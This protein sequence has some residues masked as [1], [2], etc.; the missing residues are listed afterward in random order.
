[1]R[2]ERIAEKWL[3][4]HGYRILQR[5]LRIG[6]DEADLVARDPDGRT[7]VI[8]EVKTR[9]DRDSLPEARVDHRKV[10]RLSRL[11][12]NL[13]K[14]RMYRDQ[15]LRFDVIAVNLPLDDEPRVRHIPAAFES[16]F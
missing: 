3:R 12:A 9:T 2:G 1:V 15:P 10:F 6:D 5:N 11:A 14:R 4:S 16:P 7:I 8:V 13:Q